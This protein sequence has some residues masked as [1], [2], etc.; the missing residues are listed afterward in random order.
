M[1]SANVEE[2][3][4]HRALHRWEDNPDDPGARQPRPAA[5]VDRVVRRAARRPLPAPQLRG[6]AAERPVRDPGARRV[7]VR[8]ALRASPARDRHHH[9]ARVPGADRA[10]VRGH[11]AGLG[12]RELHV[13]PVRGGV[14]VRAGRGR[15]G[16]E[17]GLEA[18]A[19]VPVRCGERSV[20]PRGRRAGA[21]H[22]ARRRL[23]RRRRAA[24]RDPSPPRAGACAAAVSRQRRAR[25][26]R[27]CRHRRRGRATE[28][29]TGAAF[30]R[31]RWFWLPGELAADR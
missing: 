13:F 3:F 23:V 31:L 12:P 4:T 11:Q 29:P 14:L 15:S 19:V 27:I 24:C 1:R 5:S 21:A 17:R 9:V 10:R 6:G 8:R 20:A 2:S 22:D 30:E 28:G 26:S 16:G 25:C 18:P 7:L